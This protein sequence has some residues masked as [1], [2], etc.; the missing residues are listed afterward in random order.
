MAGFLLQFFLLMLQ[1][2]CLPNKALSLYYHYVH[3]IFDEIRKF[4]RYQNLIHNPKYEVYLK[5]IHKIERKKVLNKPFH[6]IYK[7]IYFMQLVINMGANA[8]YI[9][10]IFRHSPD[11]KIFFTRYFLKLLHCHIF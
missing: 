7:C 6:Q 3:E 4:Y 11:C 5:G 10:I 1:Y 9:H 8:N 2:G